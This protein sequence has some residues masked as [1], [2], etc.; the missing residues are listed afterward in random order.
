MTT[1]VLRN[2]LLSARI[3]SRIVIVNAL[4]LLGVVAMLA[5]GLLGGTF[6][7]AFS[8]VFDALN[9]TADQ[10]T[11]M[12]VLENRLPRL[13]TALGVGLAFGLAGEMVQTLLRN[14]LA[15]PDVIGFSAGAA[16]GAVMSV[17]L[18]GTTAFELLGA[19]AGRA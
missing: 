6:P 16:L 18:I 1:F 7:I 13:L 4:L 3:T 17:A 12:V 5:T 14:P 9:G 10:V 15:S 19:L 8:D 2:R 11:Q